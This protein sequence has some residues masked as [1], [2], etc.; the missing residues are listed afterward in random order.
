MS[1]VMLGSRA[2]KHCTAVPE[3]G[4]SVGEPVALVGADIRGVTGRA[5]GV[6]GRTIHADLVGE[7]ACATTPLA[8]LATGTVDGAVAGTRT[9]GASDVVGATDLV[10]LWGLVHG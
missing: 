9:T 3:Q 5:V 6:D 10:G 7:L 2:A 8:V 4:P 1:S